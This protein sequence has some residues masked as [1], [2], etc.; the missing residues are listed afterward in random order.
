MITKFEDI[1]DD[2]RKRNSH[3]IRKS[4]LIFFGLL[5]VFIVGMAVVSRIVPLPPKTIEA[6]Q[7][8]KPTPKFYVFALLEYFM[9]YLWLWFHLNFKLIQ[10]QADFLSDYVSSEYK[11]LNSNRPSIFTPWAD[12]IK[13][14]PLS[15][16]VG[17]KI[18]WVTLALLVLSRVMSLGHQSS[19]VILLGALLAH[20]L[21]AVLKGQLIEQ[22]LLSLRLNYIDKAEA[23][24]V[25][26]E[27]KI[28]RKCLLQGLML[29][30]LST[31]TTHLLL[32]F[33]NFTNAFFFFFAFSGLCVAAIYLKGANKH[34]NQIIEFADSVRSERHKKQT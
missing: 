3:L 34:F 8:W 6:W 29:G 23:I 15:K 4:A 16:R 9:L 32:Q 19:N 31:G 5:I 17:L 11:E 7:N 24:T 33:S 20:E 21:V 22:Y 12:L 25:P 13:N 27:P 1:I 26:E 28:V 18:Y 2:Y 14:N 10:S 30:T